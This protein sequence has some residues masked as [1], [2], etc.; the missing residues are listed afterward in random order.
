MGGGGKVE[1][2]RAGGVG[3]L[4]IFFNCA[5]EGCL[6]WL[7]RERRLSVGLT[8]KLFGFVAILSFS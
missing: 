8:L 2:R 3:P 6:G 7:S 4:T 1:Y 5:I